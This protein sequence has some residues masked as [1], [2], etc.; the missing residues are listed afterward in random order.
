M[1][2]LI[3]VCKGVTLV[4]K[5]LQFHEIILSCSLPKYS[6]SLSV[7]KLSMI[8]CYCFFKIFFGHGFNINIFFIMC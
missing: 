4:P 2:Y 8:I 6:Y 7:F 1:D 5:R 3:A